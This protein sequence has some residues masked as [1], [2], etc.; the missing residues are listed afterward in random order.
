MS[1]LIESNCKRCINYEICKSSG[2][3]IKRDI[4]NLHQRID[5]AIEYLKETTCDFGN[6]EMIFD[7]CNAYKL[8]SILQGNYEKGN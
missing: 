8:L 5:K 4:E 2:C 3:Q 7:K 1:E 6:D